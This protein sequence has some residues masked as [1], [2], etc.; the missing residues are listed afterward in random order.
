M[1]YETKMLRIGV[2]NAGPKIDPLLARQIFERGFSTKG[3]R[4]SGLGLPVS[5]RLI[6]RFHG[7]LELDEAAETTTFVLTLPLAVPGSSAL[8]QGPQ[9]S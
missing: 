9:A 1:D 8:R 7:D 6:K 4:G 3:R 5:R 2:S